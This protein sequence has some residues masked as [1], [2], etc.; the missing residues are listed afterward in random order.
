MFMIQFKVEILLREKGTAPSNRRKWLEIDG[1]LPEK[2]LKEG[3]EW[4]EC[5]RDGLDEEVFRGVE[6]AEACGADDKD[7]ELKE[8]E[9]AGGKGAYERGSRFRTKKIKIK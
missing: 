8:R 7:E 4:G 2:L 3:G 1:I 9:T 5:V 6:G